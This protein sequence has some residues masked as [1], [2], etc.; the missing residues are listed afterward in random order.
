MPVTPPLHPA[1]VHLPL[2]AALVVPLV[3]LGLTVAL[4]RGRWPT[5]VWSIVVGLQVLV[6]GGGMMSM[7]TGEE[8]EHQVRRA[9]PETRSFIHEHEE[10]AKAFMGGAF[11]VLLLSAG[12]LVARNKPAVARGL[13]VASTLGAL[14][15]AGLGMNAGK[16]GGELVYEHNAAAAYATSAQAPAATPA[17]GGAPVAADHDD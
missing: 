7:R 12:V 4:W 1:L 3:A 5:G 17:P 11:T 8:A 10:R 16:A 6:V 15:V 13:T 2:G 14:G 9:L